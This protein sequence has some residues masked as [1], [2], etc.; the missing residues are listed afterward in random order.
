MSQIVKLGKGSDIKQVLR[1]SRFDVCQ[2]RSLASGE[3]Y[4]MV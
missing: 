3:N 1:E 2:D 4:G